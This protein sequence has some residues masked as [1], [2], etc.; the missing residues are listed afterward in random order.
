[1][2]NLYGFGMSIDW[3]RWLRS[4]IVLMTV[5][6]LVAGCS[7]SSKLPPELGVR[8]TNELRDVEKIPP[9]TIK[10]F[11]VGPGDVIEITVW[12]HDD[13]NRKLQIDPNGK[14][15]YPLL[16]EVEAAGNSV[17][18]LRDSIEEGLRQYYVKPVVSVTVG[19]VQ[20]QRIFVLGEVKNPGLFPLDKPTSVLEAIAR[21]GGFT[22]D[23]KKEN[24]F[25]VR[26][27]LD[28]PEPVKLDLQSTVEMGNVKENIALQQ[29]DI[30]YVPATRIANVSRFFRYLQSILIPVA[31]LTRGAVAATD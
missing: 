29:G 21:S 11:T 26:G 4:G 20:S 19:S 5:L 28:A 2:P 15:H 17:N 18:V 24:V 30:I 7:S 14:I 8:A 25:L 23:A 10:E 1:M 16:G 31:L 3:K 9:V 6:S 12:R 22:L 27:G 13:L